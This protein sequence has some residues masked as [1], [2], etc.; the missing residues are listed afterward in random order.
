MANTSKKLHFRNP[1]REGYDFGALVVSSPELGGFVRENDYGERSIDFSDPEAVK[2]LNRALLV[3]YYG[4]LVWD[5][6]E[7]YL[8]PAVPGR[9]DYIHY[10]ADLL[11]EENGGK[12]PKGKNIR[13]LDMGVGASCIYPIIGHRSYGWQFVGVDI[14]IRAIKTAEQLLAVNPVLK[15]AIRIRQ[16]ASD[17]SIFRGV[18]K[19]EDRFD[20]SICN[21]PFHA[22]EAEAREATAR[23][24]R[25]LGKAGKG[26]EKNFGGRSRELWY[27]G[28]E[29]AFVSK[30]IKESR[31]FSDQIR[32]FSSLI[33]KKD[34]LVALQKEL[35]KQEVKE[36]RII[37][38]GQGQKV[39]R[40]LAWRWE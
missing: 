27:P 6:P 17:S 22:S 16:Q 38:M 37:E 13:V 7:G 14:D 23:K 35:K 25:K 33:S 21:P 8:C 24:W 11:A 32:W 5:I 39:S 1:H 28:G 26:A 20:L 36:V 18:I 10:V 2:A 15:G 30:M 29:R 31:A 12:V 34:S 40:L 19:R 9:A 4:L 3:H